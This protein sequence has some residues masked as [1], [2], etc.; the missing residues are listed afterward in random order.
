MYSHEF[1]GK[2]KKANKALLL[3]FPLIYLAGAGYFLYALFQRA[4][5]FINIENITRSIVVAL[6]FY[7]SIMSMGSIKNILFTKIPSGF[8]IKYQLF[9]E[10]VEFRT[11]DVLTR[12]NYADITDVMNPEKTGSVIKLNLKSGR[13]M[14]MPI[15]ENKYE[16]YVQLKKKLAE[17]TL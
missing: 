8:D 4:P 10:Y 14:E 3:L 16:L 7:I 9:D 1:P 15:P 17:S 12:L 13:D 2:V 6:P 5:N 11:S